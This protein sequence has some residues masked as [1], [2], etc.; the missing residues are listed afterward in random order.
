MVPTEHVP[1]VE[2]FGTD[3]YEYMCAQWEC[4]FVCLR[5]VRSV[6]V[7]PL[8][9][10]SHLISRFLLN[11]AILINS[12]KSPIKWDAKYNG[13]TVCGKWVEFDE[14]VFFSLPNSGFF[15]KNRWII[16]FCLWLKGFKMSSACKNKIICDYFCMFIRK[17]KYI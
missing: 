7:N 10:R 11:F 6:T 2:H 13:L 9:F 12:W 16:H 17:Y 3:V 15:C 4:I 5:Q 14:C 1:L 8:Y